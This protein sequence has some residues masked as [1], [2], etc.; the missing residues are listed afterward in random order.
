MQLIR[1][2]T[3]FIITTLIITGC[4]SGVERAQ[5]RSY[6]A[7]E[8]IAKQR[9]E[10]IDE[11]QKCVKEAGEDKQKLEGCDSYLKAAEALK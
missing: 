4:S 8:N 3:I 10:L 5:K 7:E 9:L 2:F 6:E 1:M 11:Y